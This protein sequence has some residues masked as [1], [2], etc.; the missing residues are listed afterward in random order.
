MQCQYGTDTTTMVDNHELL[1]MR[2]E[3]RWL[4]ESGS[5]GWLSEP[6]K[7][8]SDTENVIRNPWTR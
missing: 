6:A 4:G 2:G 1:K 8:A 3:T 5:T 7:N